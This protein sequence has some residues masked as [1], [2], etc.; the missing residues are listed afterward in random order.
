MLL[1]CRFFQVT[2]QGHTNIGAGIADS[3]HRIIPFY[4]GG[5][6]R[7]EKIKIRL[8]SRKKEFSQGYFIRLFRVNGS[9]VYF[10]ASVFF[11]NRF[12]ILQVTAASPVFFALLQNFYQQASL[13]FCC[14]DTTSEW[15]GA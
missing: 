2:H 10:P 1:R 4:D 12:I 14:L 8:F 13:D 9:R 6:G 3:S 7:S 5:M 15:Q 11:A